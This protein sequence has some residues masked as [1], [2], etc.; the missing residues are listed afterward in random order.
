MAVNWYYL[1]TGDDDHVYYEDG[2][3]EN[4]APRHFEVTFGKYAGRTLAEINDVWYLNFL[5]KM[6]VEKKDWWMKRCV[7]LRLKEL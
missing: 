4:I 3:V 2:R 6:A 5:M 1:K 7:T